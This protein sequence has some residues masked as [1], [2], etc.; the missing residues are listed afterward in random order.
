MNAAVSIAI[1]AVA[2]A[3]GHYG[4]IARIVWAVLDSVLVYGMLNWIQQSLPARFPG[5]TGL[6]VRPK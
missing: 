3:N 4:E 5:A 1:G 2:A 6:R